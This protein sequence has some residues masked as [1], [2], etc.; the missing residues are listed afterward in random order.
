MPVAASNLSAFGSGAMPFAFPSSVSAAFGSVPAFGASVLVPAF[1]ASGLVPAD[2]GLPGRDVFFAGLPDD[3]RL[4][5]TV[6]ARIDSMWMGTT[7]WR[8]WTGGWWCGN[9]STCATVCWC[10]ASARTAT[11]TVVLSDARALLL[12][13]DD[14]AGLPAGDGV[15]LPDPR[16]LLLPADGT[17]GLPA[18]NGV[19]LPDPRALLLP[20]DGATGLVPA[21]GAAVPLPDDSG[22][23]AAD[24]SGLPT[25]VDARIDSMWMG[26]T[27]W[28][29]WTA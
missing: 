2:G 15:Q 7:A 4:P 8:T 9:G 21:D 1:G 25:S 3:S 10:G 18:G 16:A 29:T 17:A 13:A 27:A 20:A 28:R 12:P 6:D 5:A 26:T 24:D 14:T 22:L 19:Q 23:P 11:D